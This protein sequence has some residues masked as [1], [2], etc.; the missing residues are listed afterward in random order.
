MSTI[1]ITNYEAY[2]LDHLEGNLSP[3]D[4]LALKAFAILHPELELN[5]EEELVSLENE[6]ISFNTKQNL[7]ANFNDALVIGY[8][9][10][11]LE[12][13][14]KQ[15]AED[16]ALNNL[17]FKK[18]LEVYKKT[19]ATPDASIVFENKASLKR[20]PK[21][22]IFAQ[23]VNYRIAAALILLVGI[24]LL[25][26]KVFVSDQITTPE[27]AS[28]PNKVLPLN[29]IVKKEIE[30]QPEQKT[31]A[32]SPVQ[33]SKRT[34]TASKKMDGS[35]IPPVNKEEQPLAVVA[36]AD[37]LP[38]Q[39]RIQYLD[40][41]ALKLAGNPLKAK[42]PN[43]FVIEEGID[44]E[45]VAANPQPKKNKLFN[46]ASKALK[47]LNQNGIGKVNGSENDSQLFIGAVT[48]SK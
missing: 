5:F 35:I 6:N 36:H 12:G 45:L 44:D 46:L 33:K 47:K 42:T 27:L 26:S 39:E 23:A 29:S 21:I 3:Q 34:Y 28:K 20:K 14:E 31:L 37:S 13:K 48:I 11:V 16:L 30:K 19:I 32:N 7:K 41:N 9:E 4:T 15:T 10:N 25:I 8:L 18:E 22:L 40:T 43:T 38:K 2:M 1:N 17:I 24:W